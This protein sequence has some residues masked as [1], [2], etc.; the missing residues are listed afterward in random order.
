MTNI[1]IATPMYGGQCSAHF[2]YYSLK[3]VEMAVRKGVQFQFQFLFTESLITRGRNTL[4]HTF[5]SS[6][7]SHLM[8]IDADI[9]F[10]PEDIFKL[11]GHDKPLVCGGYPVKMIDWGSIHKAAVNGVPATGLKDY[12]SPYVYNRV[13]GSKDVNG[14]IEVV[15]AG[16]GFMMVRREVFDILGSIVPEYTSN[17]FGGEGQLH[18]EFFATSIHNGF[19][20]SEDYHFCRLWRGTGGKVYVDPGIKLQHV[21]TNVFESS[22]N[23]Q[24]R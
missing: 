18:K 6:E 11:V 5:M 7:C 15:D 2:T 12:A 20:L 16:T 3:F 24:I 1:M 19:L 23:H 14:L 21:G 13:P 4:A 22:I 8:F 9:G 10:N 17:V